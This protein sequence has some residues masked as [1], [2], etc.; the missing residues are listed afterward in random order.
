MVADYKP[1]PQ[2]QLD[3]RS[4][5]NNAARLLSGSAGVSYGAWMRG[6]ANEYDLWV[7]DVSDPCWSYEGLLPY[8][9]RVE[10]YHDTEVNMV[11]HGFGGPMHTTSVASRNYPLSKTVNDAFNMAGFVEKP[12]F[13]PRKSSW[14]GPLDRKLV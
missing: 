13:P 10:Q 4:V 6:H 1:V 12:R 5:K 3:G 7:K 2:P 14:I 9:R 8:F 11:H